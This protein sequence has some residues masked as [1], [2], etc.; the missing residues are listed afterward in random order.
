MYDRIW[1]RRAF[2]VLTG[3]SFPADLEIEIV[4]RTVELEAVEIML[5][6]ACGNA[7]YGR[8]LAKKME[9]S[10]NVGAVIAND[11]SLPMLE[12]ALGRATREG[13]ADRILFVRS[14]SERMPFASG[15]FDA[16]TC[17]ASLNEYRDPGAFLG[18]SRRVL[19]I[20]GRMSLMC[21]VRAPRTMSAA[22]Q[23]LIATI[24]GLRF[25][26]YEEL[27]EILG[28]Y[29]SVEAVLHVGAVVLSK[30]KRHESRSRGNSGPPIVDPRDL[31]ILAPISRN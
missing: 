4:A 10:G 30:L 1:R 21:Q 11:L 25:P 17:G 18:E 27:I 12:H 8:S 16:I 24:S 19:E 3:V 20:D 28:T 5:D 22:A 9:R 26:P 6:N 14:D 15:C 2:S 29:F 23:R 31:T 13:I 7:Y